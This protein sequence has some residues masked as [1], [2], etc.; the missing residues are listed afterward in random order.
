MFKYFVTEQVPV[1]KR[2]ALWIGL[3]EGIP[4]EEAELID[5]VKDGVW[6]FPNITSKIAKDAFPEINI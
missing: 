4:K 5:L 3:L 6:A 1:S 2:E